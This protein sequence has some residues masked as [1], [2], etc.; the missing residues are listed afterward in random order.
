MLESRESF[1]AVNRQRE[2]CLWKKGQRDDIL[3]VL[4]MWQ[5]SHKKRN[6][7]GLEA[8]KGKETDYPLETI[9]LLYP[10]TSTLGC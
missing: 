3:L 10:Y 6:T 2:M 4:K 9:F 7:D 1:R 5:E 8:D